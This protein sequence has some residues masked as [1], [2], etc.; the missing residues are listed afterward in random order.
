MLGQQRNIAPARTKRRQGHD[1]ERQP[2]E[3]VGAKPAFLDQLRQMLV[4][5]RDNADVD[6][7]RLGRTDARDFAIFDR[8]KQ[9]I[10]RGRRQG[11]QF[12]E[13]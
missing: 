11:R 9:P 5:R 10:L 12:V 8:A 1:L 4:G 3:Q 13:E 6:L 2:V 7:D